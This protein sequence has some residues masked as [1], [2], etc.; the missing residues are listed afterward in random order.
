LQTVLVLEPGRHSCNNL[1]S[2]ECGGTHPGI[3]DVAKLEE[4]PV[5]HKRQPE[6]TPFTPEEIERAPWLK[7]A[8]GEYAKGVSE[9]ASDKLY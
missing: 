8:I 1:S 5:A 7:Y 4:K 2:S 9:L 6:P 3:L